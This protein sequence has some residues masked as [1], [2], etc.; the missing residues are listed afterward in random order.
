MLSAAAHGVNWCKFFARLDDRLT[1]CTVWTNVFGQQITAFTIC[2][3]IDL[4][5]TYFYNFQN[6]ATEEIRI[7][8]VEWGRKIMLP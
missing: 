8:R 7:C 1:F 3:K 6:L 4:K 5:K 2:V